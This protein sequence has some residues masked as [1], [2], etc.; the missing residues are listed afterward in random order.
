[1]SADPITSP[2]T[3]PSA[4]PDVLYG[5]YDNDEETFVEAYETQR[6]A[7]DRAKH[8][9]DEHLNSYDRALGDVERF[10]VD[11]LPTPFPDWAVRP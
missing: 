3:W 10:T 11:Q 1:M 8:L 6:E 2:T 4:A 9:S 7:E 5:V